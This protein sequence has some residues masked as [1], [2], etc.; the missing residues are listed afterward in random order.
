MNYDLV[1]EV[2]FTPAREGA[3][4]LNI[5]SGYATPL[6]ASWH[7]KQLRDLRLRNINI[8]LIVGMA[9]YD[10]ITLS[11]HRGFQELSRDG[12]NHFIS[13][14]IYQGNPVHTKL[15]VWERNS[16]PYKAFAGSANYTQSG[17]GSHRREYMVDC[18][19][20]RAFSYYQ[21][22]ISDTIYSTHNEVDDLIIFRNTHPEL[23]HGVSPQITLQGSGIERMNVSLLSSKGDVADRSGLNWGQRPKREPN[24]AYIPLPVAQATTGFFPLEKQHFSVITD[25]QKQLILRVEQANNKAI[26]TP[27]NNSLL[28]EYFRHRISPTKWCFRNSGRLRKLWQNR[29]NVLQVRWRAFLHGLLCI[30]ISFII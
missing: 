25:D 26:T 10:G 22:T 21:N 6:M 24:Q 9:N 28:G 4:T 19:P 13:Q 3:G 27:L 8:N 30:T 2:L 14:Y 20:E 18:D 12:D 15:Y 7:I 17:F 23:Q 1:N 29:C 5:I 16:E 11:S